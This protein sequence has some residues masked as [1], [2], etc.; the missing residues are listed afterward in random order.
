VI[1]LSARA[2]EEAR[3]EG[4]EAG[5][6]DYL[7][8]PF[9]GRE[10][11]AR[12]AGAIGLARGRRASHEALRQVQKMEALGRLTGGVAHDF[13]NLLMVISGGL[14]LLVKQSDA[15][16]RERVMQGMRQAAQRGASLTRQLLAFSRSQSLQPRV[17]DLKVLL[18]RAAEML[19]RTLRGDVAVEVQFDEELWPVHVDPAGLELALLN[20]C[21]NARDAMPKGGAIQIRATNVAGHVQL[22]VIDHGKGMAPEIAIHAFEPFFTTKEIG[23]G[24][25]LGLTQVYSFAQSS[26][27]RAS[28]RSVPGKGTVVTLV[29]PRTTK[30]VQDTETTD[31][32]R[33][34]LRKTGSV[35]LV[36]DDEQVA[37]LTEEMLQQL[38][39]EVTRVANAASALGVLANGRE[40][41]LV[42]SD[43]MMPGG[44]NGVELAREFRKRRP[45]LPVLLTSGYA[46]DAL[47]EAERDRLAIL[48][49]P[50]SLDDLSTAIAATL[51]SA[52]EAA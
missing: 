45:E 39:F 24:S 12:V 50:Y 33:T 38:G 9:T 27:G 17:V 8:K 47:S 31:A 28:I 3:V 20:L 6:D 49:K 34:P 40:V 14:D 41:D 11:V 48:P 51:N 1:L 15:E 7:I 22:E 25:G 42:F 10:L 4:L 32:P 23:V 46:A 21:V 37:A 43:I 16:R 35:L 13:N 26:G 29:L 2:G 5:A 36:E 44:M 18:A 52:G 30:E 19:D